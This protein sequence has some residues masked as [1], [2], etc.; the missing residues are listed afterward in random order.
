MYFG[1]CEV[2][3]ISGTG[4]SDRPR[5]SFEVVL[6]ADIGY[7]L[8][9]HEPIYRTLV[10]LLLDNCNEPIGETCEALSFPSL[11]SQGIALLTEEVRWSDVH[12]WYIECL[13][14]QRDVE[15]DDRG[16]QVRMRNLCDGVSC[17]DG[18]GDCSCS[19]NEDVCQVSCAAM[20]HRPA[21]RMIQKYAT[22]LS[23]NPAM[24]SDEVRILDGGNCRL[25]ARTK[26]SAKKKNPI[27]LM[28]LISELI[29]KADNGANECPSPTRVEIAAV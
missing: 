18:N 12:Q 17:S 2:R 26:T 19:R 16:S 4:E 28:A 20:K 13:V 24:P 11:P 22:Y 10:S 23:R 7:D 6:G 25:D 3:S 8:S 27:H 15:D 21:S 29:E 14:R 1:D 9:L 5:K